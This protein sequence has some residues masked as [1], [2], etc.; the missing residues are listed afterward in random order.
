MVRMPTEDESREQG[1]EFGPLADDLENVEYPIRS[2]ELLESYGDREITL[3]SGEQ[4]LREVLDPL[5]EITFNS[6][7]DV[8]QRV[9][10][11]VD[12]EAIGREDYTDRGGMPPEDDRSE[13]SL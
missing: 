9:I 4:T 6:A 7:D 12:D 5:G 10:G 8:T 11:L 13:E 3:Q 2:A 1:V